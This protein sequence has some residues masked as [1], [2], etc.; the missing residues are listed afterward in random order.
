MEMAEQIREKLLP[1]FL[2]KGIEKAI[3]FGSI[4]RGSQTRRSDLD[5]MIII[6]TEERFF[7]RYHRFEE[8]YSLFRERQVDL[9]IYTP[10]ELDRISHRPFIKSI[11]KEGR[12]IYE[13][14]EEHLGSQALA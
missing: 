4:A 2:E 9:L 7:D 13:R 11:L 12:K 10:S 1:V 5:L 6:T 8:I 14:G 3:L